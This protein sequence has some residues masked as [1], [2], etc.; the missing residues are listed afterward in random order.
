[1]CFWDTISSHVTSDADNIPIINSLWN[2][3]GAPVLL[4]EKDVDE[5]ASLCGE[6]PGMTQNNESEKQFLIS[7]KKQKLEAA[8]LAAFL[9]SRIG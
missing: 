4:T 9:G 2:Y 8:R 6:N 3:A 7:K 1:M 5:F